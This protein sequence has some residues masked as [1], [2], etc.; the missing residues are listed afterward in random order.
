MRALTAGF[1]SGVL[2]TLPMSAV[3]WAAQRAGLLGRMP[4]A[5]I[6]DAAARAVRHRPPRGRPRR[7]AAAALHLGFG[8]AA[9][10]AYAWWAARGRRRRGPAQGAAFGTLVWLAS[11]AGWVPALG[12]LPPPERDRPGRPASMLL[13][14]WVYGAALGAGL[15]A[16]PR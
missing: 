15:R 2:A 16:S 7:V 3:M 10:A 5:K 12:I 4:P 1:A 9:G 13:A 11:Y 6:T 8:G 14:H